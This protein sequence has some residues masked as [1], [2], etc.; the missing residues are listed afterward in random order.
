MER[1]RIWY[2]KHPKAAKKMT[3]GEV[4]GDRSGER[5]IYSSKDFIPISLQ[6]VPREIN[7]TYCTIGN[8]SNGSGENDKNHTNE[9]KEADSKKNKQNSPSSSSQVK[10]SPGLPT[11][12]TTTSGEHGKV[13]YFRCVAAVTV[14]ILKKLLRN[15][16]DLKYHHEVEIFYKHDLLFDEY[17]IL[18][19]AY[20]YSW[21]K[22]TPIA[23]YYKITDLRSV[24]K[25]SPLPP[26]PSS[27]EKVMKKKAATCTITTQ[28]EPVVDKEVDIV[29]KKVVA[30]KKKIPSGKVAHIS[31][32]PRSD[33]SLGNTSSSFVLSSSVSITPIM[34]NSPVIPSIPLVSRPPTPAVKSFSTPSITSSLTTVTATPSILSPIPCPSPTT[35]SSTLFSSIMSSGPPAFPGMT[36]KIT[37]NP[38][39]STSS[40]PLISSITPV[41]GS[42]VCTVQPLAINGCSLQPVV[43][44]DKA[45]QEPKKNENTAKSRDTT[46]PATITLEKN[47]N[48]FEKI[49]KNDENPKSDLTVMSDA[50]GNQ[51]HVM[52]AKNGLS[53]AKNELPAKSVF[54]KNDTLK[55][56]FSPKPSS[57]KIQGNEPPCKIS[58]QMPECNLMIDFPMKVSTNGHQSKGGIK[59]ESNGNNIKTA[60]ASLDDIRRDMISRTQTSPSSLVLLQKVLDLIT[61]RP[62]DQHK[63]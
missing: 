26:P 4:M 59:D 48:G 43:L 7:Y 33:V 50:Q 19:L 30:K 32:Q 8:N 16:F 1:R 38:S 28:T 31:P 57:V 44:D 52:M 63:S 9:D 61:P 14:R 12:M 27:M 42:A 53:S 11:G 47:S 17:S 18:D 2:K 58:K 36:A 29:K 24:K 22:N 37:M 54:S 34:N 56:D 62:E 3:S 21:K 40:S 39:V 15:K 20:I 49:A 23:L 25:P 60:S 46:S 6:Y 35:T 45:T 51:T 41:T 10:S 5:T 13:R 55:R